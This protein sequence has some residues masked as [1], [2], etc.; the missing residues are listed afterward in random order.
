MA[1]GDVGV[2]LPFDETWSLTARLD[3]RAL[4]DGPDETGRTG[5]RSGPSPAQR[6][7]PDGVD[8]F[9]NLAKVMAGR[10]WHRRPRAARPAPTVEPASAAEDA[11]P[12]EYPAQLQIAT[13][14]KLALDLTNIVSLAQEGTGLL[15]PESAKK[16][17]GRKSVAAGARMVTKA[18]CLSLG[19]RFRCPPLASPDEL[20]VADPK[21]SAVVEEEDEAST[22]V[23]LRIER[24][25]LV[26]VEDICP[27]EFFAAGPTLRWVGPRRGHGIIV[28]TAVMFAAL[29]G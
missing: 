2:V 10:G 9:C 4:Y 12:L 26:L 20:F 14:L 15:W 7:Y 24:E 8:G 3:G 29:R 27:D 22:A 25:R 5:L 11:D 21:G 18:S 1:V 17:V 16:V 6:M 28:T 23:R 13:S 19:K